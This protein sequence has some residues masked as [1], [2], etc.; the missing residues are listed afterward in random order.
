MDE[1]HPGD[2]VAIKISGDGAQFSKTSKFILLSFSLPFLS[3]DALSGYGM[4]QTYI[5]SSTQKYFAFC[6]LGNHTF[7]AVRA[8]DECYEVLD[9]AL[10]PVF[11]EI[12]A[13]MRRKH[14]KVKDRDVVLEFYLGGDYKVHSY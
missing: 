12:N 1:F 9:T 14:I 13:L 6:I 2:T 3:N 4:L 5:V 11:N 8:T 10:R 7:A